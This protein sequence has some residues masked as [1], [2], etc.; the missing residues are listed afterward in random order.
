LKN[1]SDISAILERKVLIKD[2][3]KR[4]IVS[5]LLFGI[6]SSYFIPI[7]G[8]VTQID[9]YVV[10]IEQTFFVVLSAVLFLFKEFIIGGST[11]NQLKLVIIEYQKPE[12]KNDFL[13]VY[14]FINQNSNYDEYFEKAE[15][16]IEKFKNDSQKYT[17]RIHQSYV[18]FSFLS[19]ATIISC[20][21]TYN[22]DKKWLCALIDFFI[23]EQIAIISLCLISTRQVDIQKRDIFIFL[24][25]SKIKDS[26]DQYIRKKL[27]L[28]ISKIV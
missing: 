12:F 16:Q 19:I 17:D 23:Y 15:N 22:L 24:Q 3:Y 9:P 1:N 21:I 13:S 27:D 6:V 20:M 10:G 11:I 18:L 26:L 7:S 5:V 25:P 14:S 4:L 8:K 28:R 2:Y